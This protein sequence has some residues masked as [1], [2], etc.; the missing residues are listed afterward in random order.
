MGYQT[1]LI[2]KFSLSKPTTAEQVAYL[3]QFSETRRMKRDVKI[4]KDLFKGW[5]GFDG[6]YGKEGE[7]FVGATGFGGQDRDAS[8]LDGNYP[9][10]TQPG[11][12]CQWILDDSGSY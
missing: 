4:L 10:S 1:E 7:F 9:P 2:G 6:E 5:G 8:I 3:N 12:W 11:L